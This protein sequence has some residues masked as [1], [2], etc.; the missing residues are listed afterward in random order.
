MDG[1][2]GNV[3]SAYV[4]CVLKRNIN[5]IAYSFADGWDLLNTWK[6]SEKSFP[7]NIYA[8]LTI[9][10]IIKTATTNSLL[11]RSTNDSDLKI[12]AIV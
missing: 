6:Y 1:I 2:S 7:L 11:T 8:Q 5:T 4:Q 9:T 12:L 3:T 10:K